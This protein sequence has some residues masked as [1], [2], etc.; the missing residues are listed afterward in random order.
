MDQDREARAHARPPTEVTAGDLAEPRFFEGLPGWALERLAASAAK[1]R[2]EQRAVVVRQNDEARGA[3]TPL[4]GGELPYSHTELPEEDLCT[5][6]RR[7][8]SASR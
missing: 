3:L 6:S 8:G 7:A 5:T 4:W 2:F 1:R